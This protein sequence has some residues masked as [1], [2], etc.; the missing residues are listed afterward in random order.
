MWYTVETTEISAWIDP[1]NSK[2]GHLRRCPEH[3]GFMELSKL[4]SPGAVRVVGQ[5]TSKKRLFSGIGGTCVLQPWLLAARRLMACR[6]AKAWPH[7]LWPRHRAAPCS[8][9]KLDRNRR[10]VPSPGKAAGLRQRRRQPRRSGL[11]AVRAKD[12]G[13]DHLKALALVSR[14]MRDPAVV[15]KLRANTD[16]A[17]F[18]RF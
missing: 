16:P 7:G 8:A 13:V 6:N 4:L 10:G 15:S 11:R 5:L 3:S 2:I 1:R 9:V 17:N 12:S 18:T 14:T